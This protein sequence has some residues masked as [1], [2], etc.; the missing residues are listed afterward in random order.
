MKPWKIVL[1]AILFGLLPT[2]ILAYRILGQGTRLSSLVPWR[3]WDVQLAMQYDGHGD[4]VGVHTFLPLVESRQHTWAES[5]GGSGGS[6]HPDSLGNREF[7]VSQANV[8][9]HHQI[10]IQFQTLPERVVYKLDTGL[11]ID[12][13]IPADIRLYLDSTDAIQTGSDEIRELLTRITRGSKDE[14]KVLR[15]VF[16]FTV[17]SIRYTNY[18]GSTDAL[19]SLRLGEASCNGKSRL[20]VALLRTAKIPSRLVGGLILNA[21]T[22]KTTH[23]WTEAWVCGH[24][25]PM[26]PTNRYFAEIPE[27]YLAL[28][29]GDMV[30]FRH[31]P[32]INF[33]FDWTLKA[34]QVSKDEIGLAEEQL[35]SIWSLWK[36]F[37]KAGISMALL[38]TLLLVPVGG[39]ITVIFRNLLGF[40]PFGTFLPALIATASGAAGLGWGLSAFFGVIALG[41]VVRW[42]VE[43]LKLTRTPK[44]AV[45]MVSVVSSLIGLTWLG[46]YWNVPR[47]AHVSVFPLVVLTMTIERFSRAVVEDGLASGLRRSVVTA[48]AISACYAVVTLKSVQLVFVAFPESLLYVVGLN[49]WIGRWAGIRVWEYWRFRRILFVRSRSV[50]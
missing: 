45:I 36:V 38:K 23:Q 43:G 14:A 49:I 40:E 3:G 41:A 16:D 1:C 2:S 6:I 33:N 37:G 20:L 30:L 32:N 12:T 8:T 42:A 31:S 29:R 25:I 18:S 13:A 35:G 44:L 26:C 50:V 27:N 17:D 48:L 21:G 15:A 39:L 4:S 34:T 22:K 7:V 47:L 5:Y 9:G 10:L 19:T 24:W 11:V 28:Y 46:L